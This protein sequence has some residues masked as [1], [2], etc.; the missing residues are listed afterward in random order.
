MYQRKVIP[1]QLVR[2]RYILSLSIKCFLLN[3][4]FR[5][6]DSIKIAARNCFFPLLGIRRKTFEIKPNFGFDLLLHLDKPVGTKIKTDAKSDTLE[7]G[8]DLKIVCEAHS[9]PDPIFDLFHHS[10]V[11][12][13]REVVKVQTSRTGEFYIKNIKPSQRGNYSCIPHN[14]VGPGA[15]ALVRVYVRCEQI[16]LIYEKKS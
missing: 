6:T 7:T 3:G 10:E 2:L 11:G 4:K 15:E 1:I 9:K 16:L 14:D 8:E 13:G 5:N 12:L